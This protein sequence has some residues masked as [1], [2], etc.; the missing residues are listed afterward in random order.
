MGAKDDMFIPYI[1]SF[2]AVVNNTFF[3]NLKNVSGWLING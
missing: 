2:F 1:L 3:I